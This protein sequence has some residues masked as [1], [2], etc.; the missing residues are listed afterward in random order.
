MARAKASL[1]SS[2]SGKG[3]MVPRILGM[4]VRLRITWTNSFRRCPM[5]RLN[6][7]PFRWWATVLTLWSCLRETVRTRGS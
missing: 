1:P 6:L 4:E 7:K 5:P 2:V 3:G